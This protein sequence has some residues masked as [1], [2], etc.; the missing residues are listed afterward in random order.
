[1]KKRSIIAILL[2]FATPVAAQDVM[3]G[4]ALYQRY[5]AVCHGA[6]ATGN[7]PM[8]PVLLL[9]PPNL[10]VLAEDDVFPRNRVMARIDGRD[11]LVSHGSPMPV[12]GDFFEG[13][14]VTTRDETGL[15]VM[16]S[17]P[18]IDLLAWLESAQK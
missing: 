11:P 6:D 2:I 16:T 10:T 3:N 17:Q 13:K 8:S 15:M 12:Y 18:I 1:M 7:G 5:C 4:E 14:W 9:Q